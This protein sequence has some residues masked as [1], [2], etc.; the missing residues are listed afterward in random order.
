MSRSHHPTRSQPTSASKHVRVFQKETTLA[1]TGSSSILS[2]AS[3]DPSGPSQPAAIVKLALCAQPATLPGSSSLDATRARNHSQLMTCFA[4][5]LEIVGEIR[6]PTPFQ[7][8]GTF[9][10]RRGKE[11][12]R[13]WLHVTIPNQTGQT[14]IST[15]NKVQEL[16][17]K[18]LWVRRVQD[19][20]PLQF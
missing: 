12:S 13:Q 7:F 8:V 19:N 2:G 10:G 14:A 1:S 9:H 11:H 4:E 3:L 15:R 20:W 5:N 6:E 17:E 18:R 16:Y